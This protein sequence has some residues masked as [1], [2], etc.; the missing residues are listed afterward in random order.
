[1]L[2]GERIK[3]LRKQYGLTQVE[4]AKKMGIGKQG[5]HRLE[6]KKGE[7]TKSDVLEKL[8]DA[9]NC[10]TDYLLGRSDTNNVEFFKVVEDT[11]NLVKIPVYGK[12][13][14]GQPIEA[15]T[16]DYGYIMIDKND[17]RS[18]KQYIGLKV[19]GDSMYPMYM[20]DDVVVVEIN[21]FPETGDDVVAFIG[22]DHEATLKRFHWINR[23]EGVI[24]LE[25][26]NREYPSRKYGRDDL[27]VRILG[28]VVEI[29]REV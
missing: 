14:A 3:E 16:V 11:D 8:A 20:E 9:L 29:R 12:I 23:E 22:Y 26:L 5:V 10:T 17:L 27:P 1:M 19:I 21:P 13:P 6:G 2:K 25:P 28:K 24:E 18:G 4:L 7:A 15:L